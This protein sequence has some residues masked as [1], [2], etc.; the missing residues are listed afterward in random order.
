MAYST[1]MI[2]LYIIE[3]Y[4]ALNF[5]DTSTGGGDTQIIEMYLL[6]C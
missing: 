4:I 3:K 6:W 5:V 2:L 1:D